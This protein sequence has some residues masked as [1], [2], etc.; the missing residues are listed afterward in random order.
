MRNKDEE[1]QDQKEGET[2]KGLEAF[3]P[4]ETPRH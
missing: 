1:T 4:L 2:E 3:F